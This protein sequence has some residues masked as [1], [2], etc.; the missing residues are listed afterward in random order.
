MRLKDEEDIDLSKFGKWAI[1]AFE[2][3]SLTKNK[4]LKRK[5]I[6]LLP[7]IGGSVHMQIDKYIKDY[8]EHACGNNEFGCV[9]NEPSRTLIVFMKS[10]TRVV[11][12]CPFCGWSNK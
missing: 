7:G 11:N 2:R 4:D 9:L 6:G 8:L 10:Q 1:K 12:Y 3:N 5:D